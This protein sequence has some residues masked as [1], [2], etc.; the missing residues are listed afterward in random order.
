MEP[1]G[2][3]SESMDQRDGSHLR[4]S[5]L[6]LVECLASRLLRQLPRPSPTPSFSTSGTLENGSAEGGAGDKLNEGS[7]SETTV[8]LVKRKRVLAG[9]SK[10]PVLIFQTQHHLEACSSPASW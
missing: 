2:S 1:I 10:G 6:H 9:S 5:V 8:C 4:R 3:V 7:C